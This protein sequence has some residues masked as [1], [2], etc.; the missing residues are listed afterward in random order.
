MLFLILVVLITAQ[1]SF[2]KELN[3]TNCRPKVTQKNTSMILKDLRREMQNVGIGIYIILS[4]D[5]HG[6]EYTQDYDKRR[7][8][9]TG[10]HGSSG[11]AIV[12]LQ[13]AALWTD[14]RYFTQAEEELDCT[15]WLL[16]RDRTAGVP[17]I[18]QWLL[19][20]GNQTTLVSFS[21]RVVFVQSCTF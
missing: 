21:L 11:I 4:G 19:T 12:T 9:L 20:M 17:T 5:E 2:C 10:F 14:S 7:D 6:S 1:S 3:Q 16:M 18:T 13:T 15:N 8:W